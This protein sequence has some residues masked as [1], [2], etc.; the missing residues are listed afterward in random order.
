MVAKDQWDGTLRRLASYA[1]LLL[2]V[3]MVVVKTTAWL[4]TGSVALLT[5]VVDSAVDLVASIVTLI[6]VRYAQQPPDREHRF[7]HGKAESLSALLQSV[8]LAGAAVTLIGEAVQRFLVPH[9]LAELETGLAIIGMSLAATLGLVTFQ[10]YVVKRTGSHAIAADRAHYA[11]DI[12]INVTVLV[13]LGLTKV[14]GYERLDAIFAMGIALYILISAWQIAEGAFAVL[15][16]RELPE[17][18]RGRI[19]EI[20][21]AHEG[22]RGLHD[23][24]TRHAGDR[25]FVEFHLE[26]DP[27]LSVEQGHKIADEVE[28]AVRA[29]LPAAEVLSIKNQREFATSDWTMW[30][31]GQAEVDGSMRIFLRSEVL[32]PAL[33]IDRTVNDL[34]FARRLELQADFAALLPLRLVLVLRFR[35]AD[36]VLFFDFFV[37]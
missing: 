28:R 9:A 8:F 13:A 23:L 5:S 20:V 31:T 27:R 2:A 11:T 21:Q 33:W 14:T 3:V 24:R 26:I 30:C 29:I 19:K 10:S 4:M 15:L 37:C 1:S 12:A 22:V 25:V 6:G 36:L 18:A 32:A 16:D 35:F 7:G 34:A 17:E